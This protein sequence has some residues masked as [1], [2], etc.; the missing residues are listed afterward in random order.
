[1][2]QSLT[3]NSQ[4]VQA[5]A[6]TVP[7]LDQDLNNIQK[8]DDE[9]NDTG[10]LTAAQLKAEFD[11]AGNTIASYLNDQLIPAILAADAT[12][13]QRA[14]AESERVS[15][16]QE[17]VAN[18]IARQAAGE[19]QIRQN[20]LDNWCFVGGQ[21][22]INQRGA[23]SY[24]GIGYGVDRWKVYHFSGTGF[25]SAVTTTLGS[26]GIT[27][28]NAGSS[29]GFFGQ[30]LESLPAG[31]YTVSLLYE[32][33]SG[34]YPVAH[35]NVYGTDFTQNSYA[36]K[37]LKNEESFASATFSIQ[38]DTTVIVGVNVAGVS[39]AGQCALII[40]AI[41]LEIGSTQTLAHQENGVWEL[42]ELPNYSVELLKC[43]RWFQT[44]RTQSLRPTY[45]ADFRPVMR[46]DP[47]LGTITIE[48]VTYYTA[49]AE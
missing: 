4:V 45:G 19:R 14:L 48:G 32:R 15:N 30:V 29:R 8:L 40:K 12:E 49:S 38:S 36:D 5:A 39:S 27:I 43:Q 23:A 11:R 31:T 9:P 37:W 22:P 34:E 26:D 25:Q 42:N 20:L 41:K 28:S 35:L 2:S 16:E 18:E 3:F 47:A 44:F 24:T 10:G 21:F 6:L 33:V 7:T 13:E 17:R 1:M 46:T